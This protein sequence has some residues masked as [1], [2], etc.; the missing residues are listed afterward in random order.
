[1]GRAKRALTKRPTQPKGYDEAIA[2]MRKK[3]EQDAPKPPK[4]AWTGKVC[5]CFASH[6][7]ARGCW[8]GVGLTSA[9]MQPKAPSFMSRQKK[10]RPV[11][12][13]MEVSVAAGKKGLIA[14]RAGDKAEEV[15]ASFA[16]IW[17]L[18][19]EMIERLT[20]A[21]QVNLQKISGSENERRA[22]SVGTTDTDSDTN[23]VSD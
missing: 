18:D 11:L 21:V 13:H 6:F 22:P 12:L 19:E 2:R 5:K 4:P 8:I 7:V 15:A 10:E 20:Y 9:C 1:M 14:L 23:D 16:K 3:A 17:S